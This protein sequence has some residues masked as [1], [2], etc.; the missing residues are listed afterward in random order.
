MLYDMFIGITFISYIKMKW[1]VSDLI[2]F[3][4]FILDKD[5][6]ILKLRDCLNCSYISMTNTLTM[7]IIKLNDLY[8]YY[9]SYLENQLTDLQ[10]YITYLNKSERLKNQKNVSRILMC[11]WLQCNENFCINKLFSSIGRFLFKITLLCK[12]RD[13]W[14]ERRF[15]G[16]KHR[17]GIHLITEIIS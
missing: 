9:F 3:R 12:R 14:A 10:S 7:Q 16:L 15:Y 5:Y 4:F 11:M 6:I 8:Y 1:F 2:C 13:R 17:H